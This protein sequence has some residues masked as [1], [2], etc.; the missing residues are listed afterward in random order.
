M[1]IHTAGTSSAFSYTS[2]ASVY[3]AITAVS[4]D[5]IDLHINP[6]V[7][8]TSGVGYAL[9]MD[10]TQTEGGSGVRKFI[11]GNGQIIGRDHASINSYG[12]YLSGVEI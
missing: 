4:G 9:R 10:R 11:F 6:F 8:S 7:A 5:N 2:A 1:I 12:L 3:F